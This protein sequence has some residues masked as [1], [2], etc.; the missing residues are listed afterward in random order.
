MVRWSLDRIISEALFGW[1]S[2][3]IAAICFA[4][5][6]TYLSVNNFSQE[7]SIAVP[8]AV[9]GSILLIMHA[10]QIQRVRETWGG[11]GRTLIRDHRAIRT[12]FQPVH[13]YILGLV[14]GAT[15]AMLWALVLFE[16][17]QWGLGN[18][19]SFAF[20]IFVFGLFPIITFRGQ[21]EFTM[22]APA[23]IGAAILFGPAL[24]ILAT[25]IS[26]VADEAVRR[27]AWLPALFNV[28][29]SVISVSVAGVV[30][31]AL[32]DKD[33]VQLNSV[34]DLAAFVSSGSLYYI[35]NNFLVLLVVSLAE[36]IPI[37]TVW[38]SAYEGMA[39]GELSMIPLG[40]MLV[41]L[42]QLNP[43][44]VALVVLPI[45]AVRFYMGLVHELRNQ[46]KQA[47]VTLADAMETPDPSGYRHSQKVA[48]YAEMIARQMGLSPQEI[49]LLVISA[50][51]HDLGMVGLSHELLK[52]STALSQEEVQ[53]FQ[54][55]VNISSSL[56][57]QF[58]ALAVDNRVIRDHHE[59]F[60]GSGYPAGKK[61]EEIALEARILAVADA[62]DALTSERPYRKAMSKNEAMVRIRN[63]SGIQFDPKV[64]EALDKALAL[65]GRPSLA[66]EFE[67]AKSPQE[68]ITHWKYHTPFKEV[69]RRLVV[70]IYS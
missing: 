19:F 17:S 45:F 20:L 37:L 23:Q 8:M 39:W 1:L 64:V 5:L 47:L 24:A 6:S 46:A 55:H 27:R 51:L 4:M 63:G 3:T 9:S 13:L 66:P 30:Y 38:R 2:V 22:S 7:F 18:F 41:L 70:A 28:A 62:F 26:N 34:N 33:P 48:E 69:L 14:S 12:I 53:E 31:Y 58:P 40:A 57:A 56:L 11:L 54:R 21:V 35:I 61:G 25:L 50:R 67:K 29:Q 16:R 10:L 59:R 49:D 42:W 68:A 44:S 60:D 32:S 15:L 36:R 43:W 52:K 65:E